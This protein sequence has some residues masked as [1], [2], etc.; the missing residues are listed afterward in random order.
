[1]ARV[2]QVLLDTHVFLWVIQNPRKLS[3]KAKRLL[4]DT[5]TRVFVSSITPWEIGMKF[6][7][8]KLPE[9][10]Q[11]LPSFDQHLER[12]QAQHLPFTNEHAL[13]ASAFAMPHDDP[14]DRALVAQ[15]RSEGLTL[16]SSLEMFEQ[17]AGLKLLW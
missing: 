5:N 14:C 2:T 9:A 10:A 1:M 17:I 16:V 13:E 4:E 11:I 12:M 3:L 7:K 6:L 15:A 8:G